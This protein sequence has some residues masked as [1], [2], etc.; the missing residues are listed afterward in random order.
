M[1]P[2]KHGLTCISM[3]Q[4]LLYLCCSVRLLKMLEA[5]HRLKT[6]ACGDAAVPPLFG[7]LSQALRLNALCFDTRHKTCNWALD[8]ILSSFRAVL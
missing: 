3:Q 4:K 8:S 5:E 6:L 2:V 7:L 1:E